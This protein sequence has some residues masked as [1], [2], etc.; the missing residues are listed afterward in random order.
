MERPRVLDDQA[1]EAAEFARKNGLVKTGADFAALALGLKG[2][3]PKKLTSPEIGL[4]AQDPRQ[5]QILACLS[6]IH[7]DSIKSV[8]NRSKTPWNLLPLLEEGLWTIG[9]IYHHPM[10]T[11]LLKGVEKDHRGGQHFF[12]DE[13]VRDEVKVMEAAS[14]LFLSDR[15]RNILLWSSIRRLG[16]KH[17][18]LPDAHPV[19]PLIGLELEILRARTKRGLNAERMLADLET[20]IR[21]ELESNPHRVATVAA[22]AVVWG[23]RANSNILAARGLEIF[24]LI[25]DQHP[26]WR[27]ILDSEEQ[28]ITQRSYRQ[29]V[30]GMMLPLALISSPL[31]HFHSRREQLFHLLTRTY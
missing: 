16:E 4:I 5:L 30:F 29:Q 8:A 14:V 21:S 2:L 11:E 19:K 10:V 15:S 23:E 18:E 27:F 3:S 1:V 6:R 22:W 17:K 7:V 24:T 13:M 9:N 28:K 25:T 20:L 26:E 31:T 12:L